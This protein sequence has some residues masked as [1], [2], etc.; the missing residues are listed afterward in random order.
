[1]GLRI[2][3]C[4]GHI[5]HGI[6]IPQNNWARERRPLAYAPLQVEPLLRRRSPQVE[7]ILLAAPGAARR[8]KAMAGALAGGP[9]DSTLAARLQAEFLESQQSE[10]AREGRASFRDKRQLSWFR[11]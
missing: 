5:N 9:T 4:A 6:R 10:K 11:E 8:A 1:M 7:E 3:P 2:A